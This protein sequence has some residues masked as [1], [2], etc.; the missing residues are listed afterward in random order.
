MEAGEKH[1]EMSADVS[2]VSTQRGTRPSALHS[3]TRI[4]RHYSSS[5]LAVA[6]TVLALGFVAM[7]GTRRTAL[8]S[9]GMKEYSLAQAK[10]VLASDEVW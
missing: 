10:A 7:Q 5:S 8:E 2:L 9:E 3:E 1:A 4:M 6:L